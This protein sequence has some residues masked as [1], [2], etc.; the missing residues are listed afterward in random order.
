MLTA[1]SVKS[2][3]LRL[4]APIGRLADLHARAT[5]RA[6][7]ASTQIFRNGSPP[8]TWV[9]KRQ[10]Q[11]ECLNRELGIFNWGTG[12]RET[13]PSSA[14]WPLRS[15]SSDRT[16]C[17]DVDVDGSKLGCGLGRR[18]GHARPFGAKFVIAARPRIGIDLARHTGTAVRWWP[19]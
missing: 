13:T 2:P 12:A 1:G 16:L 19:L 4:P 7:G 14:S 18:Q 8:H 11:P 9:K 10:A 3:P 17:L 5:E 6:K 15:P